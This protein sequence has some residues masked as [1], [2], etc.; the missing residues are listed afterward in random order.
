MQ[1]L[2]AAANLPL[3]D[4]DIDALADLAKIYEDG[5]ELIRDANAIA[6]FD[7]FP[8]PSAPEVRRGLGR[9]TRANQLKPSWAR[10]SQADSKRMAEELSQL[11][12]HGD[13]PTNSFTN[14][15]IRTPE[16]STS[17]PLAGAIFGVKDNIDVGGYVTTCGSNFRADSPA[18]ANDSPVVAAVFRAGATCGG[19]LNLGEFAVTFDSPR[20][21]KVNNPWNLNRIAGGSSGG[22]AA[23]VAAGYLDFAFGTDS[24]G[25][26]RMPAAMCGIVGFRPTNGS[27][28]LAGI[29]GPAWTVDGYGVFARS[30]IDVTTVMEQ[31]DWAAWPSTG[32]VRERK[33]GV[34][35][36]GSFGRMD[37]SVEEVYQRAVNE[38]EKS[39]AELVPISLP[40]LELALLGCAAVA[41]TE[42]GWQHYETIRSDW[43]AYGPDSRLLIRLGQLFDSAAYLDAQKLRFTLG[44]KYR[45]H[46]R[47]LDA[48]VTPTI[49]ITAPENVADAR[50][51][52]DET[53][54]ALFTTI[55][56]TALANFLAL[57]SISIPAGVAH[58]GLPVGIQVMGTPFR[59]ADLLELAI[60]L[61]SALAFRAQPK[62]WWPGSSVEAR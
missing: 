23:A 37:R 61:E 20:F 19:K 25:S 22:S 55:R 24:A 21:G 60:D 35:L 59:D 16:G 12:N 36:D 28:T 40:D 39:G 1:Q 14:A 50:V 30:V 43:N 10:R 32:E 9:A 42:V 53:P 47:G 56:Y 3:E 62:A 45:E 38:L 11:V 49:P 51:Q 31:L 18:A 6:T 41:Y 29:A 46:T 34:V 48:I 33:I 15:Q 52:G 26:V 2:C 13:D 27:L 57:P 4:S 5:L 17:G 7:P 58:D 44:A 8:L 54:L